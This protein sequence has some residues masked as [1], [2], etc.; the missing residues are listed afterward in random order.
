MELDQEFQFMVDFT[1]PDVITEEFLSLIP[2][3]RH[4]V[5]IL[6]KKQK[7]LS[8]SMSLENG[9]LWAI[10][11]GTSEIEVHDIIRDLPMAGFMSARISILTF[12][13]MSDPVIPSFSLN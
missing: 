13:D 3:Q 6:F 7:L 9:K 5:N 10:F 8:Y 4:Q 2:S 11:T 12:H 1:L